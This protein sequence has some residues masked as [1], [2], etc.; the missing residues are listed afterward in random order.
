M[1]SRVNKR[2]VLAL[3]S[4]ERFN[5]LTQLALS[6]VLLAP[7][8]RKLVRKER[9]FMSNLLE[10]SSPL[11]LVVATFALPFLLGNF[12]LSL[13]NLRNAFH[14][15]K[16]NH[17]KSI[18]S[19]EK[20]TTIGMFLILV[21]IFHGNFL[22]IRAHFPDG[23]SGLPGH[24]HDRMTCPQLA[25]HNYYVEQLNIINW[26]REAMRSID[27]IEENGGIWLDAPP[28]LDPNFPTDPILHPISDE[29]IADA[30]DR[31]QK[32]FSDKMKAN[33]VK[34]LKDMADCGYGF[35]A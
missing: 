6:D 18:T 21:G 23:W 8:H 1:P 13:S 20:L 2:G 33:N 11:W 26:Y 19:M 27:Q 31:I 35:G 15:K 17:P 9:S 14:R 34:Y 12:F 29:Q 28:H 22:N 4:V 30:R 24:N 7:S 16:Q 32:Q 10:V 25:V 5:G 3:T